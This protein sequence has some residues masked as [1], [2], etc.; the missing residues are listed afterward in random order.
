[1]TQSGWRKEKSQTSKSEK[2]RKVLISPFRNIEPVAK[3]SPLA[4]LFDFRAVLWYD[5]IV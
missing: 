4:F 3:M 1:M 5:K 2:L